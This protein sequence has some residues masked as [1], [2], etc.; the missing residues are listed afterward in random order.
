MKTAMYDSFGKRISGDDIFSGDLPGNLLETE[1][2]RT[3][4]AMIGNA[5]AASVT[6]IVHNA[7]A[8]QNLPNTTALLFPFFSCFF[9]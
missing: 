9:I 6:I 8:E 1:M 3:E 7:I 5:V 2:P 4:S